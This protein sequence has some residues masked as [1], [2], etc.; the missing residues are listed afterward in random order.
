MIE[1]KNETESLKEL[2]DLLEKA[3]EST[4]LPW[5]TSK[6]RRAAEEQEDRERNAMRDR[7]MADEIYAK[8]SED[9][10]GQIAMLQHAINVYDKSELME[11]ENIDKNE[12]IEKRDRLI[13]DLRTLPDRLRINH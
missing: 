13:D 2:K 7:T 11:V 12:L 10:R 4:R 1:K 6:E 8:R 3:D 9:L 5:E